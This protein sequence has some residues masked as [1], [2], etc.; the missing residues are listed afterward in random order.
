MLLS[1]ARSLLLLPPLLPAQATPPEARRPLGLLRAAAAR[2]QVPAVSVNSANWRV[3]L[4]TGRNQLVAAAV[5]DEA[6]LK[7]LP[8]GTTVFLVL[9][10][11]AEEHRPPESAWLAMAATPVTAEMVVFEW[12][13][14]GATEAFRDLIALIK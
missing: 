7:G 13:E 5:L 12:L 8:A 1:A 11:L 10:C 14:R 6:A 4:A 9:D 2:L 3:G